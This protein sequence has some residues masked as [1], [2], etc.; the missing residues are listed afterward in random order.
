MKSNGCE[1]VHQVV[2]NVV[3]DAGSGMTYKS[4]IYVR[5]EIADVKTKL[6]LRL[7]ERTVRRAKAYAKRRGKSVS[8][9]VAD[10]FEA[11]HATDAARAEEE[12]PPLTA[13]LLGILEGAGVDEGDYLDH[14]EEK[15]R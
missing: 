1:S 3:V 7:D 13:S 10:Y 9:L 5:Q 4:G 8:R 15:H 12:L 2:S 14:L 11:L 6:T